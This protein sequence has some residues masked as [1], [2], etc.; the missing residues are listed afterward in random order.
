M[1]A[2]SEG[3]RNYGAPRPTMTSEVRGGGSEHSRDSG[4]SPVGLIPVLVP[5]LAVLM[6][7]FAYFILGAV[8]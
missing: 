8:L 2:L 3:R 5:M 6:A 1:G 4:E 7:V